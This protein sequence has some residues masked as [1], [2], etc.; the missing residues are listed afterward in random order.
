MTRAR[1][2]E[3]LPSADE[4]EVV[5]FGTG[6]GDS[7]VL[8]LDDGSWVIVDSCI[9]PE[10]KPFALEYLESIGA[11]PGKAVDGVVATH[12]H[13]DHIRGIA[14]LSRSATGLNSVVSTR[15]VGSRV[16]K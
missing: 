8:N 7:I 4:I 11:K 10:G 9:S 3:G 5:L 2:S 12:W 13:D 6:F 1:A 14:T 15:L 16:H